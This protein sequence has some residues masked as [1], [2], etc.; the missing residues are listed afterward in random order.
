M[1]EERGKKG[2]KGRNEMK[3]ESVLMNR[4]AVNGNRRGGSRGDLT[5]KNQT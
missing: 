5:R 2:G 4:G 1:K 3:D